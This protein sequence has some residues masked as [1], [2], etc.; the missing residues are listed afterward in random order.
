M[1]KLI[2]E[3]QKLD[4]VNKPLFKKMILNINDNIKRSLEKSNF[5]K[6]SKLKYFKILLIK[7]IKEVKHI[8]DK[9]VEEII[10]M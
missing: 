4:Y 1:N 5:N 3:I 8:N 6:A 7:Y 2:D 9:R 10:S